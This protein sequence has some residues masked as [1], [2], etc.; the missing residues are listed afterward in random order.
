MMRGYS[1]G[2]ISIELMVTLG[3]A[4]LL[5]IFL[6]DAA[7]NQTSLA[8]DL[9]IRSNAKEV[10]S[11][12]AESIDDVYLGGNNA[13][14]IITLPYALRGEIEY[15]IRVYPRS[16]LLTYN[17]NGQ[18]HASQSILAKNINGTEYYVLPKTAVRIRNHGGGVYFE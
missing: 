18:R 1:R 5:F 12:V 10:V 2:Q 9:T 7:I 11:Y 8:K 16:V 3:I 13:T 6:I 14:K 4:L 17:L 15:N